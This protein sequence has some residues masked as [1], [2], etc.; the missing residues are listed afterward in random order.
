M[1]HF[2]LPLPSSPLSKG[3]VISQKREGKDK[4]TTNIT[5]HKEK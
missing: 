3:F 4:V 1:S 5:G 2:F